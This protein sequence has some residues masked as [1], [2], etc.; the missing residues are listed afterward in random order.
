MKKYI[1][2]ETQI[3]KI[4][5]SQLNEEVS[6][7]VS[8]ASGTIRNAQTIQP[9]IDVIKK[10]KSKA[11]VKLKILGFT[12]DVPNSALYNKNYKSPSVVGSIAGIAIDKNAKG[13]IF[14]NNTMITLNNGSTLYFGIVGIDPDDAAANGGLSITNNNGKMELDFAWD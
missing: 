1:F 11:I 13:K 10:L 14:D 12:S 6:S 8:K 5:D 2:T 3:K 7:S 4:I 9:K